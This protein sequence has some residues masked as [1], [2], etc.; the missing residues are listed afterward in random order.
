[1]KRRFYFI[2]R[3]KGFSGIRCSTGDD[4]C[5]CD[6]QWTAA[7]KKQ[8][9]NTNKDIS[10]SIS[11]G[12]AKGHLIGSNV[13]NVTPYAKDPKASE[14]EPNEQKDRQEATNHDEC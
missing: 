13:L 10:K 3:K 5:G 4:R 8:K 14:D 7:E 6:A 1:M 2:E 12:R 9:R 11:Y